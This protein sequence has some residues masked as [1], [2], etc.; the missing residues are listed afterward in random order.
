MDLEG[1]A[2]KLS[3]KFK[4]NIVLLFTYVSAYQILISHL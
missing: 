4:V 3:D 1:V 2:A